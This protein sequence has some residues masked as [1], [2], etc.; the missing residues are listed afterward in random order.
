MSWRT[1]YVTGIVKLELKLGFLVVR[2]ETTNRISLSEIGTVI[3]ESTSAAIT[4]GLLN[5]LSRRKIK[6]SFVMRNTIL[7]L[8]SLIIM[9]QQ[10]PVAGYANRLTGQKPR[11][12]PFGLTSSRPKYAPS[13]LS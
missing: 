12:S 8:N 5:E 2:G 7:M 11:K 9:A 1:I 4:T 3:I 13:P 6:L 10:T